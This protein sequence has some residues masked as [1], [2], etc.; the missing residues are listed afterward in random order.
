MCQVRS[1][2]QQ[3]QFGYKQTVNET[4]DCATKKRKQRKRVLAVEHKQNWHGTSKNKK[5]AE[6]MT[7]KNFAREQRLR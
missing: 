1:L 4:H 6:Q 5:F 3:Q 2:L 7:L